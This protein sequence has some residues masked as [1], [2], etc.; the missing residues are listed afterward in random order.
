M[1]RKI[2]VSMYK[3]TKIGTGSSEDW[4]RKAARRPSATQ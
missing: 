2:L 1:T 4:G 3:R